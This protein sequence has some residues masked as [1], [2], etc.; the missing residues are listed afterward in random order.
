MT[1]CYDEGLLRAYMEDPSVMPAGDRKKIETH[2]AGCELCRRVLASLDDTRQVAGARMATLAPPR[3]PDTRL[4]LQ[5]M[6]ARLREE[7]LTKYPVDNAAPVRDAAH[8]RT[9]MQTLASM[10]S[11][12]RRALFSGLAAALLI[13]SMVAFPSMRAAADEFLQTFR[14]KQ[15]IFMPVE[16][17]RLQ[18]LQNANIDPASLFISKPQ[19]VG[20][21][22]QETVSSLNEA[23]GKVGFQPEAPTA[24]PAPA[25]STQF[26][27]YDPFT[28]QAQVNV[29][30]AR[31]ALQAVGITDIELPDALGAAPINA[32]IPAFVESE[33]SGDA[34][35]FHLVQGRTPSVSLPKGVELAQLGKAG[36]RV[37]GMQPEQADELSRQIDWSSTLVVPFPVGVNDVLRVQIGDAQGLLV[38]SEFDTSKINMGGNHSVIYWQKGDRFYVLEGAG[39][40]VT[41]DLMLLVARS[42]K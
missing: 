24:F 25:T 36:L 37:L 3:P 5:K 7:P 9:A 6:Q 22:K 28:A 39:A 11:G 30:N 40:K 14:A 13:V 21:Q 34:Y 35:T 15:V 1:Q 10:S 4:A 19:V 32:D 38:S 33:Y 23:A 17:S 41:N 8:R 20:E 26:T 31:L 27:V 29:D 12:P 2:L 16:T 42:V 18:Q